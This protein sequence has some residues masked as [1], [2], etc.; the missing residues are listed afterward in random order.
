MRMK[1]PARKRGTYIM[2]ADVK[3][4]LKCLFLLVN[5]FSSEIFIAR[6]LFFLSLY[7]VRS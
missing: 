1:W 2:Q 4:I 6:T 5:T 7:T 3:N